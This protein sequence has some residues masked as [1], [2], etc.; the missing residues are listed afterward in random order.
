MGGG[1]GGRVG[2]RA[3]FGSLMAK[4]PRISPKKGV[5][6]IINFSSNSFPNHVG[7]LHYAFPNV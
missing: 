2:R 1:V 7:S 5:L 4:F 3:W 6:S